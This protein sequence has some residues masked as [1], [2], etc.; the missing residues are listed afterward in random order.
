MPAG[1]VEPANTSAEGHDE[2]YQFADAD[3]GAVLGC[4]TVNFHGRKKGVV[5]R[6]SSAT[7][8]AA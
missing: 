7:P 3:T 6:V 5:L 2:W 8:C 4:T 1:G